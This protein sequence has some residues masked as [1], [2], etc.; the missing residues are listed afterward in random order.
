MAIT[1]PNNPSLND[2]YTAEN[3]IKYQ[4]DGEKWSTLP[5]DEG[6]IP[7]G[8]D[9]GQF[10]AKA[11]V[12]DYDME[13]VDAAPP[14]AIGTSPPTG[15]LEDGQLWWRSDTGVLYIYYGDG[16]S[17]QWVQASVGGDTRL[18]A[19]VYSSDVPPLSAGEGDLWWNTTDTN[20]YVY[21]QSVWVQ[22]NPVPPEQEVYWQRNDIDNSISPSNSGDDVR[23]TSINGGHAGPNNLIING[24]MEVAQRGTTANVSTDIN[25]YN[26]V[27]RWRFSRTS[28]EEHSGVVKQQPITDLPGFSSAWRIDTNT[29]AEVA[30]ES[31][32]R[33]LFY[34]EIEAKNCQGLAFGTSS[35]KN[36]T[37]SFW[38][39]SSVPGTYAFALY[40]TDSVRIIGTTY[41]IDAADTWEYKTLTFPGDTAGGI[42]NDIGEG[43]RVQFTI[44]AGS[45]YLGSDNTTWSSYVNNKLCDGHAQNGVLT[46]LNAYWQV[47]GCQLTATDTAVAFQHE[48]YATTLQKCQR[49]FHSVPCRSSTYVISHLAVNAS[50]S[51]GSE[52]SW[53]ANLGF[54]LPGM[55]TTP[56]VDLN[57][58]GSLTL[59]ARNGG[60]SVVV[61]S[62]SCLDISS[63]LFQISPSSATDPSTKTQMRGPSGTSN[64][65][66]DAEL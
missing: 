63:G 23:A 60:S 27:D 50:S 51:T 66:L 49:Y 39:K 22:S 18:Q 25:L 33:A 31:G 7:S 11:S 46:T 3:G 13:W 29:T 37:C 45:N 55:R 16:N 47:T 62:I 42:N 19:E 24:A 43:V 32:D 41:T 52:T 35:A 61:S 20:L 34:Q 30:I 59:R 21:Y 28:L 10:L 9:P 57:E 65:T 4:W 8:G 48:D 44:A 1:F 54:S 58:A 6:Q 2:V 15:D 14:T 38:V 40:V 26:T 64:L 5:N 53:S 36:L 17:S 12:A 56:T